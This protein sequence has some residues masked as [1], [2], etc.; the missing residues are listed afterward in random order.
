MTI[1]EKSYDVVALQEE[2]H[3][4]TETKKD[5]MIS[6]DN[7][8]NKLLKELHELR[9]TAYRSVWDFA[10]IGYDKYEEGVALLTKH[11]IIKRDSFFVTNSH[12]TNFWKTRKVVQISIDFYGRPLSFLT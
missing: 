8:A 9:Y 10:H 3:L 12:D 6:E 1:H 2:R 7:M 11:P 5:H 4:I